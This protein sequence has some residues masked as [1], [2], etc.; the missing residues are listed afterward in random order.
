MEV[1]HNSY[2]RLVIFCK[3]RGLSLW[4][5]MTIV[6]FRSDIKESTA[7]KSIMIPSFP[8]LCPPDFLQYTNLPWK[9]GAA[10]NERF[11]WPVELRNPDL[12]V[13]GFWASREVYSLLS[14]RFIIYFGT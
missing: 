11:K 8:M 10:L 14:L 3:E 2:Q 9:V 6:T 1:C 4:M 5:F 7:Q 12:E 13:Q